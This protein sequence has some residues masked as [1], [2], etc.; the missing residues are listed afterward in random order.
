[1]TELL[2][3]ALEDV[4]QL[5][6]MSRRGGRRVIEQLNLRNIFV[7]SKP[8][9]VIEVRRPTAE[10]SLDKCSGSF[11]FSFELR[12][13]AE[14]GDFERQS[15]EAPDEYSRL[16]PQSGVLPLPGVNVRAGRVTRHEVQISPNE[17]ENLLVLEPNAGLAM[18]LECRGIKHKDMTS[19][20]QGTGVL[21][22]EM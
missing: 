21:G 16:P 6:L 11:L 22:N 15:R 12:V 7:G 13:G 20:F 9:R 14:L 5:L 3:P 2:V 10:V 8:F 17:I 4:E 19:I 1:V 18:H